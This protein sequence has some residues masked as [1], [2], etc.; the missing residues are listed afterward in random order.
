MPVDEHEQRQQGGEGG[1]RCKHSAG[2]FAVANH[3]ARKRLARQQQ[4]GAERAHQQLGD[5]VAAADA[6]R[7]QVVGSTAGGAIRLEK[8]QGAVERERQAAAEADWIDT[9]AAPLPPS[10]Y[11]WINREVAA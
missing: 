9:G 11:D 2:G 8:M 3:Q 7:P 1:P 10:A 5:H 4:G 6:A